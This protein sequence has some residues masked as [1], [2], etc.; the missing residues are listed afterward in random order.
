MFSLCDGIMD[1]F[2]DHALV[3]PC[4]GD[5]T[6][7]YNH[8]RNHVYHFAA[9][10]GLNPE[11]EKPGLLEP[12]PYLGAV[13]ENGIVA[14][15]PQARRPADVYIPRWRRG[16]PMALDFAVTSGM[17]DIPSSIRDASSAATS[18]EDY[19]RTY[20]NTEAACS[21]EGFAFTPVVCEAVG[22]GWGPAAN[23]IFAKV[24]KEE[25]I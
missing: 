22:G 19:K 8:L 24:A 4:G 16:T 13:P 2:G 23:K 18:Y 9:S 3:C 14:A 1:R 21:A 6:K 17:R 12:R 11:L 10:S 7:G 25:S 5:R 15:D 20:L